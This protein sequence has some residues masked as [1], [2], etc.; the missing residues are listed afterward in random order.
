MHDSQFEIE[1]KM[2]LGSQEG[3]VKEKEK[4]NDNKI[5]VCRLE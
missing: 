1:L 2:A 5:S 4:K 3:Y